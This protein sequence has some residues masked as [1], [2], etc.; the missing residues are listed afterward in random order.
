MVFVHEEAEGRLV[1]AF[2]DPVAVL[3]MTDNSEVGCVAQEV[4]A[5]L[6][7]VKSELVWPGEPWM[8]RLRSIGRA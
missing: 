6:Q 7:R 1:V 4:C 2:M 5:R 3:Q 8:D